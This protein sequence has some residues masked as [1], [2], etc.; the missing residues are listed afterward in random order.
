MVD[1][2]S[3]RAFCMSMGRS[4]KLVFLGYGSVRGEGGARLVAAK[5]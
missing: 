2:S 1:S 3:V 4:A 5:G